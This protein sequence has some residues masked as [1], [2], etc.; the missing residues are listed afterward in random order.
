MRGAAIGL[1]LLAV[2]GAAG[3]WWM[4]S[5]DALQPA[6]GG[7][8]GDVEAAPGLP[9]GVVATR[10]Q[11]EEI[12]PGGMAPTT[13]ACLKIVDNDTGEPLAGVVIRLVLN[14]AD[15]AFT[16]ELGLAPIAIEKATQLAV[17][18]DEYLL[19]LAPTQLGSSER[20]PQVVRLVRDSLS[21]R[22]RFEFV[23]PDGVELGELFAR[24]RPNGATGATPATGSSDPVLRRVWQEHTMLAA[25]EVARD[26]AVQLGSFDE[27]RVLRLSRTSD[28]RFVMPGDYTLEVATTSGL[29]GR[30]TVHVVAGPLPPP[31]RVV[32]APGVTLRGRVTGA[33]D[34]PLAGAELSI[35]GGEPLGLVAK[36][37]LDG[38]F[39]LGP[40]LP[41]PVTL[42]ARCAAHGPA[43]VGPFAAAANDVVIVL[44]PLD[45]T[46]LRGRVRARPG[47][48]P[49]AG[50]TLLWQAATGDVARATSGS[51][52]RF[53][54]AATGQL[55]SRL[56]VQADGFITYMELVEPTAGFAEYD[57]WP[58]DRATRLAKGV[59]GTLEG[60]VRGANGPVANVSVRWIPAQRTP[61]DV[62][63]GR[64]ALE[65]ATLSLP[66]ATTTGDDGAF[67]L[68]TDQFGP[69]R[70]V[71]VGDD[72][73]ARDV[74]VIAGRALT[75]LELHR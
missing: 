38:S 60:I 51:D 28:V 53:E 72:R 3:F 27:Q 4:R 54:L 73:Q 18:S 19:R 56:V 41:G 33:A 36:S 30:A 5:D 12:E 47:L 43:A 21:I 10:T 1:L 9:E 63:P 26:V 40:L 44:Q 70:L 29:V 66:P 24:L 34:V 14:G 69:G 39:G 46:L 61:P 42:L 75:G 25:R 52:G 23:A 59:T 71:L 35:Q 13:T 74:T 15:V 58:A 49:I 68:E 50:A 45:V 48:E 37:S 57:L 22:R 31:Q 65:G 11:V 2:L 16:D 67:V 17:V 8:A 62:V 20:E 55:A 7:R 32:L 6:I 64:R